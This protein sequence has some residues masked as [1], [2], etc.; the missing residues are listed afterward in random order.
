MKAEVHRPSDGHFDPIHTISALKADLYPVGSDPLHHWALERQQRIQISGVIL[1]I[2]P[3]EYTLLRKL[4]QLE[5]SG[6]PS[7]YR[8]DR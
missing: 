2:A 1:W 4:Q 7:L 8:L 5:T 6:Q 3:I